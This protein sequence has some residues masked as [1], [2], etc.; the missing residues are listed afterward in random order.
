MQPKDTV[1]A[2]H[3]KGFTNTNCEFLPCHRD[4]KREFN[5]LFCYCPLV[6]L[7][8]PGHYTVFTDANGIKRKDCTDCK[9][10]HDGYEQS[11]K[12]IQKSLVK[13]VPWN[14]E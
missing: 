3:F 7:E 14:G 5:C 10:P 6:F 4:I 12:F 2:I 11:W 1:Q 9:L 13:L 8:C